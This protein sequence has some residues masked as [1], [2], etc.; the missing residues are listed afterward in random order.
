MK[1]FNPKLKK[2]PKA[3]RKWKKQELPRLM[4]IYRSGNPQ[5]G[6][7]IFE[8]LHSNLPNEQ[9]PDHCYYSKLQLKQSLL[10][11]QGYLCCYCNRLLIFDPS[12]DQTSVENTLPT[13]VEHLAA[14]TLQPK[15]AL[16][17]T[18][19]MVSCDGGRLDPSGKQKKNVPEKHLTCNAARASKPLNV[20]PEQP[21][22]EVRV[23]YALNG[24]A[25]GIDSKA[26]D[27]VALL[28]LNLK[29]LVKIRKEVIEGWIYELRYIDSGY[30]SRSKAIQC[31]QQ[32][33]EKHN[34]RFS[35]F[36]SAIIQIIQREILN[37]P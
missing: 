17:Y 22:C 1:Y 8:H 18:N 24:E 5:V 12:S 19:L 14:V 3:F 2:E 15:R 10:E 32:L 29:S 6:R 21:D 35:P 28:N 31:I 27:T 13:E 7:A 11:D 25:F 33:Q 23:Q 30:I 26:D 36:S 9:D 34:G 4:A 37:Q 20:T 16:D